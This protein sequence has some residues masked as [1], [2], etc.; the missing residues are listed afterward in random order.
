[1]ADLQKSVRGYADF[2]GRYTG[3][4]LGLQD[5]AVLQPVVAMED[6]LNERKNQAFQVNFTAAQQY[7][8][9]EVPS[10]KRWRIHFVSALFDPGAAGKQTVWGLVFVKNFGGTQFFGYLDPRTIYAQ[11]IVPVMN[12]ASGDYSGTGYSNLDLVLDGGDEIG[13]TLESVAAGAQPYP[14]T[15]MCQYTE[16]SI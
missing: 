14:F 5:S 13:V 6:F 9:L 1:M 12:K 8:S 15:F 4:Q 2:I 10:G 7:A 16:W 3:G 11:A